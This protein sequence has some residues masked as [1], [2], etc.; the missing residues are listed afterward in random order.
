MRSISPQQPLSL[1]SSSNESSITLTNPFTTVVSI[2]SNN[3]GPPDTSSSNSTNPFLK[4]SNPFASITEDSNASKVNLNEKKHVNGES[5]CSSGTIVVSIKSEKSDKEN[6][7]SV[8]TC[9]ILH[10]RVD[11]T[12]KSE[13]LYENFFGFQLENLNFEEKK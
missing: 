5:T 3:F 10:E 6:K 1:P 4:E 9:S 2:T 8:P 11:L 13:A 7:V 12:E